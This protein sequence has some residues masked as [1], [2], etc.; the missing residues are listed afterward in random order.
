MSTRSIRR[1][2]PP[3]TRAAWGLAL[4][5]LTGATLVACGA[6]RDPELEKRV[7]LARIEAAKGPRPEPSAPPPPPPTEAKAK[8]ATTEVKAYSSAEVAKILGAVTGTGNALVAAFD[9]DQGTITCEL[10]KDG[11]PQTVANF[12]GL[13]TG[14]LEW[15]ANNG[16]APSTA[17]FY[18]GL[19]FYRI[20][21]EYLIE[22]GKPVGGVGPGWRIEREHGGD[23][24]FGQAGAM[25]MLADGNAI[26]GSRFF[27]LARPDTSL[28]QKYSAFGVCNE[29]DLVKRMAG[30][31]QVSGQKDTPASPLVIRKLR[32]YRSN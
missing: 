1:P 27:I 4:A 7:A 2:Y 22:G 26:N 31:E 32:I 6:P 23:G 12:V 3:R 21:P 25:A 28:A 15:K 10:E 16:A 11:A 5:S 24:L 29:V 19:T 18:D 8:V 20:V 17:P 9:T 14:Q 30:A 13:A